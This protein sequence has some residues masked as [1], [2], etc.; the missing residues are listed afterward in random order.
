[1]FKDCL[2]L[3][4]VEIA[5]RSISI[6]HGAFWGCSSLISV[7]IPETVTIIGEDA[8]RGCAALESLTLPENLKEIFPY[9]FAECDKLAVL[10]FSGTKARWD[11]IYRHA[12][13]GFDSSLDTVRCSDGDIEV[14]TN[15]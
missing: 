14:K 12:K 10:T 2:S 11:S 8:F 3:T 5:N 6:G 7:N 1:L 4:Q 13:W 15:R 9:A